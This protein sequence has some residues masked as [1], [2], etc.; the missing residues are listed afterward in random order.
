[1][2]IIRSAYF[3][4][5]VMSPDAPPIRVRWYRVAQN[6]ELFP[7]PHAFGSSVWD[8]PKINPDIGEQTPLPKL[9]WNGMRP[10]GYWSRS[11]VLGDADEFQSGQSGDLVVDAVTSVAEPAILIYGEPSS[12]FGHD[13]FHPVN[14]SAQG[15]GGVRFGV[16]PPAIEG[17]TCDNCT[18]FP[19]DPLCSCVVPDKFQLTVWNVTGASLMDGLVIDM[20]KDPFNDCFWAGQ[21]DN[22][23]DSLHPLYWVVE[24]ALDSTA[25]PWVVEYGIAPFALDSGQD[26]QD[27]AVCKPF[28]IVWNNS[29]CAPAGPFAVVQIVA[30]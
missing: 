1:M 13:A 26:G 21:S 20:V 4:D 5:M 15:M 30:D 28:S 11:G 3:A 8:D 29:N 9:W 27:V 16:L 25:I 14:R 17:T 10:A 24:N 12:P 2:D 22:P 19:D 7:G 6:A 23:Y 18:D